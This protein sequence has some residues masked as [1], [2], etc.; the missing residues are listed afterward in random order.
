MAVLELQ[1]YGR[2]AEMGVVGL[3]FGS[4]T[5]GDGF[6]V[7]TTVSEI[8]SN[9]EE[10]ESPWK[11]K[12]SDLESED[13]IISN[14]G[15]I[16]S[17]ISS[18][19]SELTDYTGI[20][21]EKTG[22]S[23]DTSVLE[24]TSATSSAQAGTHTVVVKNL[25]ISSTGYLDKIADSAD[26]LS[27]SIVIQ[28]GTATAHTITLDSTND[29]LAGLASA[30]NSSGAGVTANVLTDTNGS[31]LSLVSSTSG[32][33]GDITIVS[34]SI[35]DTT[36]STALSY[37][38]SASG[39]DATL[40]VDGI[41]LTSASNTVTNLI[42]GLTFS[43]LSP[44]STESDG[45]YE[46]VQVIIAN[47]NSAIE[48]AI[49][50]FVTDYNSLVSAMNVQEGYDSSGDAEPLFGSPTLSML[51]QQLLAG[52]NTSNPSGY[53]DSISSTLGATLAGSITIQVGT[54]TAQTITLDSSD[55]TISGLASAIN[56]ADIGV[57]AAVVTK[58]GYSTL[59]LTSS[60][61]GT[62]GALTV[63]SN[64]TATLDSALS[65]DDSGYTST[66]ADSGTFS[67][68]ASADVLSGSLVIEV[69]SATAHTISVSS[70]SNTLS[71]LVST[72][73]A[74][75]IGVTASISSDKKTLTLTSN[76]SGSDGALTVTSS[77]LDTTA[78][79]T[80][81]LSYTTSSDILT[82]SGLGV[83][84]SSSDDGM[85]SLDL[86]TLD[87]ALNYDF[88]SVVGFFQNL[89]SWGSDFT[90]TLKYAGT[91]ST[92]GM[93]YLA[94]K[95]NSSTESTLNANISREESYISAQRE[96]LTEELTSANEILQAIPS[97]ISEI[98][99]LY[100]AITGYN[101][102]S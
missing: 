23:S 18:D 16:L 8:V 44:S 35:T 25:A 58:S 89:D 82:L 76:T 92:S 38:E 60:T 59:T 62:N 63:T 17:N 93:L 94:L 31:R 46:E 55:N 10:V 74:A 2:E 21:S 42:P 28:I 61:T 98:N 12:L 78:T 29:T 49:Y 99:L 33:S 65:F 97:Q 37:N 14:F 73:N 91:S 88:S 79:S 52:L 53:L 45:S 68:S 24:L 87:S 13:T 15:S 56:D 102:S 20:T 57:T 27:G 80:S 43:I 30:I 71:G 51:Q 40:V 101:Q 54:A 5:S 47:D 84:A 77:L 69:G 83:T 3:S 67:V 32:S 66:T 34:N 19:L 41:T 95:A 4:P 75:N 72:I 7:S 81:A 100:S 50:S 90:S 86:E 48:S 64:I 6:D 22:S 26:V 39:K 11:T 1:E 70:S 96:S 85:L 9:L 36:T